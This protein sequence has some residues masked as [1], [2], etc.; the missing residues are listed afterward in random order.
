MAS[1]D[2]PKQPSDGVDGMLEMT[3]KF[4]EEA[5]N[6]PAPSHPIRRVLWVVLAVVGA[7]VVLGWIVLLLGD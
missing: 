2:R 7:L 6:V 4:M 1:S 5:A 3:S